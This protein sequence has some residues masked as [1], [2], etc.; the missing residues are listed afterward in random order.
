MKTLVAV[1]L[2]L[3][4]GSLLYMMAAV[5]A[6]AGGGSSSVMGAL[7][8]VLLLGG[9]VVSTVFLLRGS[10]STSAVFRRGFLL[11]AGEWAAMAVACV[12]MTVRNTIG[13]VARVGASTPA[14]AGVVS[15]G[16][17]VAL[18]EVVVS[19][20]LAGVCLWGFRALSRRAI[21]RAASGV[22]APAVP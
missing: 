8:I 6:L 9:S 18:F 17:K 20:L 4:S 7:V 3:V 21:P 2:G 13:F 22:V 12:V 11:G 16:V 14:A 5:V 10:D 19:L 15:G 1:L